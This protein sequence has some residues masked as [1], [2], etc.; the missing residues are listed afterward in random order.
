MHGH[1]N[2]KFIQS[3]ICIRKLEHNKTGNVLRA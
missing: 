1:T 3:D 2:I